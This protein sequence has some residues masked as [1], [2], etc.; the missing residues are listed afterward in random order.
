MPE[1]FKETP[2][3]SELHSVQSSMKIIDIDVNSSSIS[4]VVNSASNKIKLL[5]SVINN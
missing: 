2:I 1:N 5:K 4:H 3:Y